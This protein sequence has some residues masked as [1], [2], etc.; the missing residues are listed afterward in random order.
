MPR[1]LGCIKWR[2][3]KSGLH[4]CE[5]Y[6]TRTGKFMAIGMATSSEVAERR[7]ASSLDPSVIAAIP[8]LAQVLERSH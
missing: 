8:Q 6:D 5:Y 4:Y 3:N 1:I 7:A 2:S